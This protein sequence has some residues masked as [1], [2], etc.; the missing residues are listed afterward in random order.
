[1]DEGSSDWWWWCTLDPSSLGEEIWRCLLWALSKVESRNSG[2]LES[3][4]GSV[5]R[6]AWTYRVLASSTFAASFGTARTDSSHATG[7]R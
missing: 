1:M 5:Q 2:P 6:G 7:A 4:P 3:H